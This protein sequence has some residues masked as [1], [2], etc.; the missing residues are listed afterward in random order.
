MV[1]VIVDDDRAVGFADLGEAALDAVEPF[2]AGNDCLV[3]NAELE[4]DGDRGQRILDVV[5]AGDRDIDD[6]ERPPLAVAARGS[7]RRNG[8]RPG[9]A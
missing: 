2:E 6:R 4:R 7:P 9:P 8:C 5:P 1:G 3:R